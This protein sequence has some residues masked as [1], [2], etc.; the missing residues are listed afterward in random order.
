MPPA[1]DYLILKRRAQE[2]DRI[3]MEGVVKANWIAGANAEW[4]IK[5]TGYVEETQAQRRYDSIRAADEAALNARRLRLSQMLQAEQAMHQQQLED[6]EPNPAERKARMEARAAELKEKRESERLAFVRQQY[7]RQWRMA[8]DP[9][10]EQESKEILKATSAARAYQI[11]EKMKSLELEEQE[12]RAFDEMWE[13]DRLAKLGREEAEDEA[14]KQMDLQHKLV[15]DQ[16]VNELASYRDQERRLAME[17]AALMQE[18][19]QMEHEEERRVAAARQAV[20]DSAQKELNGFN[21]QRK[22]AL[23][24]AID[25]ERKEDAERLAAVLAKEKAEDE[26]E[27][28]A[29]ASMQ[30]ETRKFGAA[31]MAQ[32]RAIASAEGEMEAARKQELNKAWDKRLAVWQKEQ[33]ARENLLAQV[34]AERRDQVQWKLKQVKIDKEKAAAARAKLELELSKVNQIEKHKTEEA[35]QTRMMHRAIL[36]NQIKAKAFD[37]AAGMFNKAQERSMAERAEAA[38]QMMLNDQMAKTSM[39]MNKFSEATLMKH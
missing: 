14:R 26:R 25:Q 36:E 28:R 35:H 19:W 32:K 24:N 23:A 18:S 13:Q 4:E 39:T 17:E 1:P 30:E 12:N 29:H 7:E 10:R 16:Q 21:K 22:T 20:I 37:R 6:L 33:E 27:A 3:V 5:T 9:L 38:Y 34:L 11:G 8:C 31:M 2:A 15:L